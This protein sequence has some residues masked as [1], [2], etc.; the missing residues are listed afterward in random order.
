VLAPFDSGA[1]S[2]RTL[3]KISNMSPS[4][5]RLL[6]SFGLVA[7]LPGEGGGNLANNRGSIRVKVI[8]LVR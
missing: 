7:A 4:I 2:A 8:S 1:L 6:T 3:G 5:R